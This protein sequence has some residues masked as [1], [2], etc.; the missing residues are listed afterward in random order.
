MDLVNIVAQ[1]NQAF[2]PIEQFLGLTSGN[3][4][5]NTQ[6]SIFLDSDGETIQ[7]P[8][9]PSELPIKYPSTNQTYN[10]LAVGEIVQPRLPGLA[11]YRWESFFPGK[12]APYIN[13]SGAFKTPEFYIEKINGYKA[14]AKSVRLIISRWADGGKLFD[15]NTQVVIEDFEVTEKGGEV[16]DFYYSIRLREYRS[17]AARK[18]TLQTSTSST[19]TATANTAAATA[20]STATKT[21]NAVTQLKRTV[22]KVMAVTYTVRTADTLWKIAKQQLGDGS[23]YSKILTLNGLPSINSIKAGMKLRM[24]S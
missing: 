19:T 10:L 9:M 22:D 16:G 14:A 13:T 2:S 15:T 5:V 3:I 1:L 21:V 6:Y 8:V 11:E 7:F 24:P 20:T 18:V 23:L 17:Y 12:I 4:S